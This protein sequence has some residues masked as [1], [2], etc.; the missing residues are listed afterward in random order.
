[1]RWF[2]I[3]RD[4]PSA[5]S[6]C[7]V[8]IPEWGYKFHM[9]DISATIGIHNLPYTDGLVRQAQDNAAYYDRELAGVPGVNLMQNRPDRCSSCWLYTIR[10][11]D[12]DRFAARMRES[13]I[14]VS[15]VHVRNDLQPCVR[16]FQEPLPNLDR[17]A[18]EMICIPVGW[19]L[20]EAERSHVVRTIQGGW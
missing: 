12:R 20:T 14:A 4:Q 7:D 10:V 1:L 8:P 6:R 17:L 2:G 5:D 11:A 16:E 3:D 19:W 9:N 13:G 18:R 15:R